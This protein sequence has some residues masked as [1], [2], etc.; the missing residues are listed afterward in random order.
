MDQSRKT[1]PVDSQI[2]KIADELLLFFGSVTT[3]QTV[4][5]KARRLWLS[6]L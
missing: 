6:G 1:L 3:I 5:F 2:Q 4:G